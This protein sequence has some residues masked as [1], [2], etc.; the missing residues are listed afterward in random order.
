MVG[1]AVLAAVAATAAAAWRCRSQALAWVQPPRLIGAGDAPPALAPP[2]TEGG[3]L[4]TADGIALRYWFVPGVGAGPRPAVVLLHGLGANRDAMLP[5]AAVLARHGLTSL[6]VELRA[7]GASGGTFTTLGV[8]EPDDVSTAVGWLRARPDVASGRVALLGHSLGAVVALR[9][10]AAL[11][12]VRA[13]VAESA[14]PGVAAIAP[15]VVAGLTGRRP[16]P[17]T[18]AVLW[19]MDWL[20]GAAV[21]RVRVDDVVPT[22][23]RPVLL[24]HGAR[25][26]IAPIEAARA[27]TGSGG[28]VTLVVLPTAAHVD[29][30]ERGGLDYERAVSRFL[31]GVLQ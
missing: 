17:S 23:Q 11:P 24:V 21:S 2:G 9:A 15:A 18:A 22:L 13:V 10:A 28:P 14:F 8:R 3:R 29:L 7:H 16:F 5:R 30:L 26:P 1:L 25:D 6:V 4:T 12:G 27:L 20:T 19:T 31:S